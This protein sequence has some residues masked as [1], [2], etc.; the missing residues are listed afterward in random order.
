MRARL[1]TAVSNLSARLLLRELEAR[2][3]DC[4]DALRAVSLD[5][6]A[7][8]VVAGVLPWSQCMDL[9]DRLR[10][11]APDGGFGV[12]GGARAQISD[13]DLAG[14]YLRSEP[15][16]RQALE[17]HQRHREL[18][19]PS[20]FLHV[21]ITAEGLVM[22]VAPAPLSPARATLVECVLASGITL[23]RALSGE[24]DPMAVHL[25]HARPHDATVHTRV[26]GCSPCFGADRDALVLPADILERRMPHRDDAVRAVLEPHV[27]RQLRAVQTQR[28]D[29][30]TKVLT[31]VR[32]ALVDGVPSANAIAARLRMSPRSLRRALQL[33]ET[34]YSALLARARREQA[35]HYVLTFRDRSGAEIAQ[36]LHYEDPHTFYRAFKRWTGVSLST[37]RSSGAR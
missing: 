1:E 31:A 2:G 11:L 9:I 33:R 20:L 35:L 28:G 12:L 29:L 30:P 3:V 5:R 21:G 16:T 18:F 15:S 10:K 32:E 34:S 13:L 27:A 36:R 19:D 14:L 8:D 37:Y 26:F 7:L 4:S 17:F 24:V 25:R 6:A 22:E 23:A